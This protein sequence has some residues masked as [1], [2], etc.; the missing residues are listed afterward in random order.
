MS[1]AAGALALL[2]LFALTPAI[3]ATSDGYIFVD[4]HQAAPPSASNG[5]DAASGSAFRTIL[6]GLLFDLPSATDPT[7]FASLHSDNGPF[8]RGLCFDVSQPLGG[9]CAECLTAAAKKIADECGGSRR[10]GVWNDECFVAYAD[11]NNASSPHEDAYG[12]GRDFSADGV[13][14]PAFY[15][16]TELAALALSLAPRAA[17]SSSGPTMTATADLRT[18]R[19]GT[20]HAVALCPRDVTEADCARCLEKSAGELLDGGWGLDGRHEGV[21]VVAGFDCHLRLEIHAPRLPFLQWWMKESLGTFV[22]MCVMAA[23]IVALVVFFCIK[24]VRS[25]RQHPNA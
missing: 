18:S 25:A 16:A 10:A 2:L 8:V 13:T 6:H 7:G 15:N 1:M 4:C 11:N 14:D 20:V 19:K 22:T 5:S 9:Y 17:N 23:A 12:Y 24:L 3:L 21:A